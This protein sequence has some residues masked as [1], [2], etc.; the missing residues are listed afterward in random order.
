[1]ISPQ[2]GK[3]KIEQTIAFLKVR[4]KGDKKIIPFQQSLQSKP[5]MK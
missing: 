5:N 1:L 2:D 4:M 3:T